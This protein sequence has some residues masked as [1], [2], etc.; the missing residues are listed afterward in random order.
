MWDDI[1][2]SSCLPWGCA[3]IIMSNE[4]C[5]PHTCMCNRSDDNQAGPVAWS[6]GTDLETGYDTQIVK[7]VHGLSS[8]QQLRVTQW[9][10]RELFW[11]LYPPR[12]THPLRCSLLSLTLPYCNGSSIKTQN[13]V[14]ASDISNS[15]DDNDDDKRALTRTQEKGGVSQAR[16]GATLCSR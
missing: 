16:N 12:P 1:D 10:L 3:F 11:H 9:W 2:L 8:S 14:A 15:S 6:H 13:M 4:H 7:T 5:A